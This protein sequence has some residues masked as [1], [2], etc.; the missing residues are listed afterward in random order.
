MIWRHNPLSLWKGPRQMLICCDPLAAQRW[1]MVCPFT[2]SICVPSVPQDY[3]AHQQMLDLFLEQLRHSCISAVLPICPRGET[4]A[5]QLQ[6]EAYS[7]GMLRAHD[8]GAA[9]LRKQDFREHISM[10]SDV[11]T[12]LSSTKQASLLISNSSLWACASHIKFHMRE[13]RKDRWFF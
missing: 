3:K 6:C 11:E 13:G 9:I 2:G 1:H 7:S 4:R 10:S 8:L 12:K 5:T